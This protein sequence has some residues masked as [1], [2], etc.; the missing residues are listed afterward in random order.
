MVLE[1]CLPCRL[2]LSLALTA[3][4]FPSP[5]RSQTDEVHVIPRDV[6]P[7]KSDGNATAGS[8]D[9]AFQ[10]TKPLRADVSLVLVPVTVRD[11]MNRPVVDLKTDNFRVFEENQQQDLRLCW[12]EDSPISVG[13]IL[14][15]SKSMSNKIEMETA[16]V[17]EFFNN[18]NS[19]DDY[20]V[21]AV[22][23]R[24]HVIADSSD[25]FDELQRRMATTVPDGNTALLDGI[26]VGLKKMRTARYPRRAL[27][28][29][30][31]GGDNHSYYNNKKIK[32]MAEEAD[33]MIYAIG[34]FD[35]MPVPVFK[36]IE[37]KLGQHLLTEITELTGG[38]T[39]AADNREKLPAVAGTISRALREQYILAY[40]PKNRAHDGKWKK[41]KVQVMGLERLFPLHVDYKK[42]YISP[43]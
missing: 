4:L 22:S 9:S 18:A 24:P 21:V 30:S 12:K 15:F 41:I 29:I 36:T 33:V 35:N 5:L 17:R 10:N 26:Y 39:I 20:F 28:I 1:V 23:D 7:P 25:S 14:D 34:I 42:G 27:L 31:D 19:Q 6:H 8:P 40:R 37:E 43:G 3:I 32:R 2:A 38:F 13:V 11:A 16:A